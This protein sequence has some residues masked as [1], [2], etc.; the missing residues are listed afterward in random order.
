[1]ARLRPAAVLAGVRERLIAHERDMI[2]TYG[3]LWPRGL[4]ARLEAG[5]P[6][7]VHHGYMLDLPPDAGPFVVEPDGQVVEV[8]AV[9][10]DP[11]ARPQ[12]VVDYQRADGSTVY[13]RA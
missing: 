7:I 5:E 4:L 8:T 9:Y 2:A 11:D 10:A 1:M 12:T 3:L 6:V 13:R